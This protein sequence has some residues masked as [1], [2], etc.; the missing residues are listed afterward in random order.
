LVTPAV[1]RWARERAG[2]DLVRGAERLGIH[3]DRLK[4]WEGGVTRPTVR[5]AKEL[6]KK[7]GQSFAAL[8]LPEPPDAP[9]HIPRDYRRHAGSRVE[10]ISSVIRLEVE[11]SWER[12]EIALELSAAQGESPPPFDLSISI[13]SDPETAGVAL[14]SALDAP[15][16]TQLRLRDTRLTFNWWRER[17]E[18]VG[19]LVLQTTKIPADELRAYS[20]FDPFLP[21]IVVNRK[22]VY[23]ARSFSLLHELAHLALRTEGLCDLSTRVER[24]PEHQRL[25][26]FCN[27]VAAACLMPADAVLRHDVVRSH[28]S[29]SSEW[30][31]VTIERLARDFSASRE[32]LLRR[33]LTFGLTTNA[34]YERKRADYQREY[35]SEAHA[36]AARDQ[37][38]IIAPP[39]NA[40][41]TLGKP[42]VRLVLE[43]LDSGKITS[44]DAA[45]YLGVRI[46]HLSA[47]AGAV[48]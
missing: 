33:L 39:T 32:A 11:R 28:S 29:G 2:F 46:K 8:Y 24:P 17:V 18:N 40:V 5:Q 19:V 35:E 12:R 45:D 13:N 10:D 21:V 44:T 27:A 9:L 30:S 14:R 31:D 7:F 3:P 4:A 48:E 36:K 15:L 26:V 6:A 43:T 1:V 16:E 23:G 47:L 42:F 37:R 22:D 20:L 41:S 25:E 38:I 34:F